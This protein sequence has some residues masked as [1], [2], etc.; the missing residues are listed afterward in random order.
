MSSAETQYRGISWHKKDRRWRVKIRAQQ[1]NLF[2]GNYT[3]P[4][5]AARVYDA[6]AKILHG[7]DAVLNF[8]GDPPQ[9]MTT[10]ELKRMLVQKGVKLSCK[11]LND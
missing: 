10:A 4:E 6:A 7:P 1:R 8:D 2:L 5:Y 3:D 9:G 11:T